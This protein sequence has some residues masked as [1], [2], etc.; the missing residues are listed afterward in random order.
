M[1]ADVPQAAL[2]QASLNLRDLLAY[3]E[4][5]LSRGIPGAVW[6]RAEIASL[7]DRRHLYLDLVQV[8]AAGRELAKCR[9]TLWA[10]ERFK[11]EGKFLR[12]TGG[13]LTAGMSVLLFV[14]A[15]FHPQYGFSLHI[16]DASPEFTVGD[17]ALR[18]DELRKTLE[19]EK[20]LDKNRSLPT[21]Q[22]F[23]RVLVLSPAG[24]AGLGDFR[25]ELDRLQSAGVLDVEYFEAT[26]QGAS[27]EASLLKALA[28]ASAAHA[29]TAADAL[30]IIRGGGASLDLAWLNTEALARAVALFPIPVITGIGH[31]RDDTILDEL[32]NVRTDTP[33]KAAAY[34]ISTVLQRIEE[35]QSVYQEICSLSLEALEYAETSTE[36]LRHSVYAAAQRR[37]DSEA[38]RLDSLMRQVL[39]LTPERT[40]VRG[41][42]LIRNAS[43]EMVTR[44][45]QVSAGEALELSFQDGAVKAVAQDVGA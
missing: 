33:S 28:Q 41:Y 38:Q 10:S 37:A 26:F 6:V 30:V 2:P 44:A 35:A 31:A 20:L 5:V 29:E 11:L 17:A 32:A 34:L 4:Q 36:R 12:A 43:G 9:A 39:G 13:R 18:L 40:L 24:A 45:S 8:D 7:T 15:E 42:A 1:P 19:R 22:D 27:A 25:A 21:P 16:L 3:V 14:M 23:S